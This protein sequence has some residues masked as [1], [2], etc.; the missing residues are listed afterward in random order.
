MAMALG[1]NANIVDLNNGKA[2]ND[3]RRK[4]DLDGF[5]FSQ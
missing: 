1:G 4:R 3:K 2:A 5:F